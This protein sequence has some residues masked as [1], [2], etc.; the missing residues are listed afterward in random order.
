MTSTTFR[1]QSN[2]RNR[3]LRLA[4]K[5]KTIIKKNTS[6]EIWKRNKK[7]KKKK[8]EKQQRKTDDKSVCKNH[9]MN[10]S[11]PALPHAKKLQS[12]KLQDTDRHTDSRHHLVESLLETRLVLVHRGV[13]ELIDMVQH[14]AEE[15]CT[16]RL[17]LPTRRRRRCHCLWRRF[18]LHLHRALLRLLAPAH[19]RWLPIFLRM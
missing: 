11:A 12:R 9:N 4:R 2:L 15:R 5:K 19:S 10:P 1:L 16:L 13:Y 6:S 14:V 8:K 3:Q 17:L 7:K 18:R